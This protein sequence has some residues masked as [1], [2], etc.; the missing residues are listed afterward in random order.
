MTITD[1][2]HFDG[3]NEINESSLKASSPYSRFMDP[4][5]MEHHQTF[6]ATTLYITFHFHHL[7]MLENNNFLSNQ[8]Q[9]TCINIYI[10]KFI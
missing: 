7:F 8:N 3:N 1:I 6:N 9:S 2:I 5:S 10:N 4:L